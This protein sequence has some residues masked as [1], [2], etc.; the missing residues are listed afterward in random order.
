MQQEMSEEFKASLC[1]QPVEVIFNVGHSLKG[2]VCHF[3]LMMI[4]MVF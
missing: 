4:R 1:S 2:V 3:M